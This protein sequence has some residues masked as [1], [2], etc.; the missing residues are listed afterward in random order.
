MTASVDGNI[1]FEPIGDGLSE[2][3][4]GQLIIS[5]D[6]VMLINDG[7]HRFAAILSA[8]EKNP[9]LGNE[10]IPIVLF[11]DSGLKRSQQMFADLNKHAIK[12]T[13]SLVILYDYKSPL[14]LLT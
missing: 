8:L 2:Y 4:I 10:V 6:S 14:P 13:R 11:R 1:K 3:N 5:M 7:Q 12:P 9:D